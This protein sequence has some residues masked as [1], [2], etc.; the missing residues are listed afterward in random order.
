[1]VVS[2]L[3]HNPQS[4]AEGV[5]VG[6]QRGDFDVTEVARLKLA[7]AWLADT[8]YGGN[9]FLGEIAGTANLC[10]PKGA[11]LLVKVLAVVGDLVP[12]YPDWM[13]GVPG[14]MACVLLWPRLKTA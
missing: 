8:H 10:Q 4:P 7:D 11:N 14:W 3:G 13:T 5:H 9:L 2:K 6:T 1:M 12:A